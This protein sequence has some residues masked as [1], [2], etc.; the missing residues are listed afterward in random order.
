MALRLFLFKTPT[1]TE[2]PTGLPVEQHWEKADLKENKT[3]RADSAIMAL[4]DID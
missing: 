2:T 4:P 3:I 1:Y